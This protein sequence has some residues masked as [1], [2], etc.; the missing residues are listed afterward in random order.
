MAKYFFEKIQKVEIFARDDENT[1]LKGVAFDP[2]SYPLDFPLLFQIHFLNIKPETNYLLNLTWKYGTKTEELH[3]LQIQLNVPADDM[4]KIE[5]GYGLAFGN[6]PVDIP[7]QK[8]DEVI[9]ELALYRTEDV[10]NSEPL[11]RFETYLVFGEA[12]Q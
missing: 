6:F 8:A 11:S 9:L 1:L 7:L 5:D 2:R 12:T 3:V 4:I 10:G